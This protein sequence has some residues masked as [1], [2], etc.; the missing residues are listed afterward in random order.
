[1]HEFVRKRIIYSPLPKQ[2]LSYNFSQK[3]QANG[4]K[5]NNIIS[6]WIYKQFISES[7]EQL[8]F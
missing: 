3:E 1:M 7:K 4:L 2:G 8:N 6:L 5:I